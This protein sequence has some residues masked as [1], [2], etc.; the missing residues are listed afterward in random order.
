MNGGSVPNA[1]GT[2]APISSVS[3]LPVAGVAQLSTASAGGE[4]QPNA[5][6]SAE[7]ARVIVA[8]R[9]TRLV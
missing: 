9:R 2:P 6:A 1:G 7:I 5:D 3:M 4:P 8:N